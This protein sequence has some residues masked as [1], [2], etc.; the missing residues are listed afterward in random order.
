MTEDHD[1]SSIV[2]HYEKCLREFGDTPQGMDWPNAQD[3]ARR[4]E[5][6]AGVVRVPGRRNEILDLGCG[7]GLFLDYLR[8]TDRVPPWRYR[9]V[10]ISQ[11]MID[12]AR[13]KRGEKYF[14]QQDILR[15]PLGAGGFDYV[16]MNGVLTEK[17]DLSQTEMVAYAQDMIAAAFDAARVGIAFNV[18]SKNV[19]WEREDLFHWGL[20]ELTAFLFNKL[21]R[22]HIIRG[23]YGLY[24]Y[25]AYVFHTASS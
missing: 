22:H 4:F 6:M 20:D 23:D 10:D 7:S 1:I 2:G 17:R 3:L 12:M 14:V 18:M 19:E 5:V 21:S 8:N 25:T 24:E 13:E 11:P 9:G 16:L 15:T